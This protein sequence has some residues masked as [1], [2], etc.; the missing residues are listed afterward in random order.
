MFGHLV[1]PLVSVFLFIVVCIELVRN[2]PLQ[3]VLLLTGVFCRLGN[4][5]F[6]SCVVMLLYLLLFATISGH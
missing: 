2:L 4:E 1:L 3:L 6:V 5:G